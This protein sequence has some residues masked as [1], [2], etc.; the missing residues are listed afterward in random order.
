MLRIGLN[1]F[2]ECAVKLRMP[3]VCEGTASCNSRASVA[4]TFMSCS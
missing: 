4:L 1:I 2:A 3:G